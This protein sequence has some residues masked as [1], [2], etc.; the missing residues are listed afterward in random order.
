[1]ADVGDGR[2]LLVCEKRRSASTSVA[3][4]VGSG[5]AWTEREYDLTFEGGW[6]GEPFRPTGAARL[7]GG[8]VI[9]LERRFPP[10]GARIARLDRARLEGTGPLAPR[11]IAR[12][13]APLTLD[14]FEGIEAR[15]DASGRTLVYLLSDD[16]NCAKNVVAP[17][18]QRTLLL[19]FALEG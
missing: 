1:M 12:F 8:D 10:I 2:R 6:G 15:R 18:R 17:I 9:V 13:E 7:P 19:M 5:R 4:W 14:N 16:N 3:A 11:E